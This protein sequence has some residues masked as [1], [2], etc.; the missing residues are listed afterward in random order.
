MKSQT[1]IINGRTLPADGSM[2]AGLLVLSAVVPPG[3]TFTY[4][5]IAEVCGVTWQTIQYIEKQALRKLRAEFGE[6]GIRS[7]MTETEDP[8]NT[9]PASAISRC[10]R[11]LAILKDEELEG[12]LCRICRG[13]PA[14]VE[15]VSILERAERND[16]LAPE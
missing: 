13:R 16:T 7:K 1:Q 5:E 8:H 15:E 2:D 14:D 9:P 12:D 4:R 10:K 6:R 3:Q 11:C